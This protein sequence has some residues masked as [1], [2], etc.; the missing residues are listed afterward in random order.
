MSQH[1]YRTEKDIFVWKKIKTQYGKEYL[2]E[3]LLPKG[4][5][6]YGERKKNYAGT[7][8]RK[9]RAEF[10]VPIAFYESYSNFIKVK[11]GLTYAEENT[12]RHTGYYNAVP[13]TYSLGEKAKPKYSFSKWHDQC[14]S[15]IHFFYSAK[16]ALQWG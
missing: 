10:L 12:L 1:F 11:T 9:N 14:A 5:Y 15:G 6:C 4:T 3:S 16:D 8:E 13:I 2:L 7:H